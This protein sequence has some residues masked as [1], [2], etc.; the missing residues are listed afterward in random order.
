MILDVLFILFFVINGFSIV[1][2]DKTTH[3]AV[4][5]V[6]QVQ[7]LVLTLTIFPWGPT[8]RDHL[9]ALRSVLKRPLP[10]LPLL[11]L[12]A[13]VTHWFS[14]THHYAEKDKRHYAHHFHE[15]VIK[16]GWKYA[17]VPVYAYMARHV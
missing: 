14:L 2:G 6:S 15:R 1:L 11:T 4:L 10:F 17:L 13:A 7:Y 16:T 3:K 8:F 9:C 5:H 12:S